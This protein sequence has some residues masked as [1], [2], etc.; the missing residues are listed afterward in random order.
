LHHKAGQPQADANKT[1][2]IFLPKSSCHN[3]ADGVG[4]NLV[5]NQVFH[6]EKGGCH[7]E[8][9]THLWHLPF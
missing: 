3:H 1:L 6:V 8:S 5:Q 4:Q 2:A 9:D 7:F